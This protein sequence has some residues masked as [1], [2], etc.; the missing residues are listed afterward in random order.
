MCVTLHCL[1]YTIL[2]I[3][4]C[5]YSLWSQLL[6]R[7]SS[8]ISSNSHSHTL[9]RELSHW[10]QQR[11]ISSVCGG[12]V[13]GQGSYKSC[14]LTVKRTKNLLS[15]NNKSGT[16][17]GSHTLTVKIWHQPLGQR[18]WTQTKAGA[19]PPT[20]NSHTACSVCSQ[21]SFTQQQC[22]HSHME[23]VECLFV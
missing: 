19:E 20:A 12:V 10:L 5:T 2:H 23:T 9:Q 18:S 6:T 17:L 16:T 7:L 4:A 22:A 15:A 1:Y 11:A 14:H 8:I 3:P 21:S 13:T